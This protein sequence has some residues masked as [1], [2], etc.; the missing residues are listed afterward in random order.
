MDE[1]L[2]IGPMSE[3]HNV[4]LDRDEEEDMSLGGSFFG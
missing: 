4:L 3:M 2:H 1:E